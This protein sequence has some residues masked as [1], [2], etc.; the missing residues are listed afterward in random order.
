[1]ELK[2]LSEKVLNLFGVD[3][4]SKLDNKLKE[5]VLTNDT[6]KYAEFVNIVEDLS[7]DW[8]QKIYQYYE[9]DRKDKKQDYTPKSLSK[10]VAKLTET[11]GE[12]VY[13]ICAGSG[14]L[15]IQKWCLSPQ[16]T[17]ICEELDENV[18]PYL[19]FNMAVRNMNGYMIKIYSLIS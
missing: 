8:M 14:A 1:M 11:N 13:D 6:S 18:F 19:A 5:T 9:A 10:L 4:V 17:F 7:I 15:T 3:S 16:K 2:E 12:V